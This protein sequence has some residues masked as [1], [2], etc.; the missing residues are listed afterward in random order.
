[1][2][3]DNPVIVVLKYALVDENR[4]AARRTD[5][6]ARYLRSG[7]RISSELLVRYVNYVEASD[8]F[9]AE[10]DY[11]RRNEN[12]CLDDSPRDK[13]IDE[14]VSYANRNMQAAREAA[15]R[16]ILCTAAV[17]EMDDVVTASIC[18]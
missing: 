3:I 1:V 9:I 5:E 16:E 6:W 11:W 2:A 13:C 14:I 10:R 15:G 18:K 17:L 12:I 7:A 8:T 4:D